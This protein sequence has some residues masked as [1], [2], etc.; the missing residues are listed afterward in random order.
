MGHTEL[1]LPK[2]C[3]RCDN[4]SYQ[5]RDKKQYQCTQVALRENA[6]GSDAN[7]LSVLIRLIVSKSTLLYRT[8]HLFRDA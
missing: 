8:P 2:Y 1:I 7:E 3:H 4:D 5:S 6:E